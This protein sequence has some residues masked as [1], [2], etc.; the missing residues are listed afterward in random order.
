MATTHAQDVPPK[1]VLHLFVPHLD[2]DH[3]SDSPVSREWLENGTVA[4]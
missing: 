3:A 2:Q 4:R 1:T